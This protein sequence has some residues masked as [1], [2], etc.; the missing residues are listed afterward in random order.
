[1]KLPTVQLITPFTEDTVQ[2]GVQVAAKASNPWMEIE[3]ELQQC[4]ATQ[5]TINLW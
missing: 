5:R 2:R 3:Q 1:M 4:I